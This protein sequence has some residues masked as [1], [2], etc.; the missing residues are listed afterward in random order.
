MLNEY[1]A[2]LSVNLRFLID[3]R[4][5][6]LQFVPCVTACVWAGWYFWTRRSHWS[7]M[8]EG[9]LV[10][11]VSAMCRP[12]GWFFD[13]SV[14]L[15]AV[16]TGIVRSRKSDRSLWPIALVAGAALME[17][18]EGVDVASSS[19]LWTAPAWLACYVYA[20]MD[21]DVPRLQNRMVAAEVTEQS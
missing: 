14:L 6:W 1:V 19:Y 11:L 7:W 5:V 12:Y 13:E 17:A 4:A 8:D 3:R 10:L 9:L 21:R 16:L 15:P 20:T 18:F 2:T